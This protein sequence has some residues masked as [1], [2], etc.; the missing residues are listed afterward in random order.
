MEKNFE[1]GSKSW[2]DVVVFVWIV[3]NIMVLGSLYTSCVGILTGSMLPD[4]L[5]E[6]A[7]RYVKQ[8]STWHW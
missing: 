3:A 8:V 2:S 7:L 1:N 6:Y 5:Y 4:S